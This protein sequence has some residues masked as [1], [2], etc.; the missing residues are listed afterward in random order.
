M[1]FMRYKEPKR[2]D[3]LIKH[4][5]RFFKWVSGFKN[6][7]GCE[8]EKRKKEMLSFH[9]S[10]LSHHSLIFST[11]TR[12]H[13]QMIFLKDRQSNQ[14]MFYLM[15]ECSEHCTL[16]AS[17]VRDEACSQ[18]HDSFSELGFDLLKNSFKGVFLLLFC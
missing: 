5:Q 1:K 18:T 10:S 7:T 12:D 9:E 6:Q 4:L 15:E 11:P 14:K 8:E 2:G 17:K 16:P 13:G 3:D